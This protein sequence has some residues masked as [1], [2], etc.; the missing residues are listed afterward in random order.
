MSRAGRSSYPRALGAALVLCGA[1]CWI[2][3]CSGSGGRSSSSTSTS[4]GAS[5][6]QSSSA[7]GAGGTSSGAAPAYVRY[8]NAA[9]VADAKTLYLDGAQGSDGGDGSEQHPFLT[10]AHAQSAMSAGDTLVIAGGIYHLEDGHRFKPAGAGRGG[11][12]VF[13]AA[14]GQRVLFASSTGQP[15]N[16]VGPDDYVR[17]EG[18]W[19]GGARAPDTATQCDTAASDTGHG[20][21]PSNG[22]DP[23]G[24]GKAIVGCTFFGYDEIGIG[25]QEDILFQGNRHVLTGR[26]CYSHAIYLSGGADQP[27]ECAKGQVSNHLIVDSSIFVANEGYS[28]HGYHIPLS[29]IITRNVFFGNYWGSVWDGSDLLIASNFYWKHLGFGGIGPIGFLLYSGHKNVVAIDNVFGPNSP[30]KGTTASGDR[31]A[32]N[33]FLGVPTVGVTPITLAAGQEAA[34][35]GLQPADV[36]AAV[37]ALRTALAQPVEAVLA[38]ATIEPAFGKLRVLIPKG[39]PLSGTGE[40]WLDGQPIDVGPGA[41]GPVCQEDFWKAFSAKGLRDIDRFCQLPD[42]GAF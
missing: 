18:L 8:C 36:D 35:L 26:N 24:H 25:S 7:S 20:F 14:S 5:S 23:V 30:L 15:P 21:F 27:G 37:A 4:G 10:L 11:Q 39:S 28:T 13:R 22:P 32:T 29:G 34:D 2:A 40:G 16:A 17:L 19:F 33:A 31:V 6:A 41:P 42:G 12:T 38:D 3:A 9:P 1:A